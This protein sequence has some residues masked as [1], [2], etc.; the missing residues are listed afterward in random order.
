MS[1][2]VEL[3]LLALAACAVLLMDAAVNELHGTAVFYASLIR[4]MVEHGWL[5]VFQGE[6]AYFLKPPLVLWMSAASAEVFGLTNFAVSLFPRLAGIG[7][8]WLTYLLTKRLFNHR[9]AALAAIVLLTNSTFIQFSATLRMDSMLLLGGLLSVYAWIQPNRLRFSW[10]FFLGLSIGVLSKG[11]L[12]LAPIILIV[13]H[14]LC[15]SISLRH[16]FDWKWSVLLLPILLWYGFLYTEHGSAPF[17][18]LSADLAKP[19]AE[20]GTSIIEGAVDEYIL[21]PLRRYFPWLPFMLVGMGIAVW[22][23]LRSGHPNSG[24]M[25]W[26]LIWFIIVFVSAV[27]KPDKDI[28]YL[29]M[30]LPTLAIFAGYTLDLAAQK[31]RWHWLITSLSSLVLA[32]AFFFNFGP[33]AKPDTRATITQLKTKLAENT[34]PPIALGGYPMEPSQPRRQNTHRDWIYFYIGK[35]PIVEDWTQR[36]PESIQAG[37][38]FF[39]TNNRTHQARLEEYR[40]TRKFTTTEMVYAVR[41]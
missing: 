3:S 20:G 38:G 31:L 17:S 7:C 34:L 37:E 10:L 2:R 28:R 41:E 15:F 6:R 18:Q 29:Y 8:V 36:T 33:P 35:E 16:S 11:P 24:V 1:S 12:G 13:A 22:S 9:V 23:A 39:L 14:A 5:T 26:L 4:E 32:L 25:R 21:K 19:A 40:L 30:A 27:A